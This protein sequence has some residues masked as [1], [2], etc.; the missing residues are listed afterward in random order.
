[1]ND[2]YCIQCLCGQAGVIGRVLSKKW[3]KFTS[4]MILNKSVHINSV[5]TSEKLFRVCSVFL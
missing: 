2:L 5:C 4:E 3:A 1:M